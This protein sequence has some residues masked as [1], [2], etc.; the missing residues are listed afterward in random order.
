MS[1]YGACALHAGYLRLHTHT[2]THSEC[3]KFTDL[4]QQQWLQERPLML[5]CS[6]IDCPV[7]NCVRTTDG[8]ISLL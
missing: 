5:N 6:Y 4:G 1:Q 7:S 8:I 3:V 2:H